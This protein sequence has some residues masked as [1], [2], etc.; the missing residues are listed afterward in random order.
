MTD[1]AGASQSLWLCTTRTCNFDC[2][3]CYQGSHASIPAGL[4]KHM[5]PEVMA[6]ALP[7]AV[8]WTTK[9]LHV[10]WYG[11]EPLLSFKMVRD[12]VPRW[13]EGFAQAGKSLSWSVTTNGS[14]LT[15]EV[16]AWLDEHDF[17]VL[18]SLDGPPRTHDQTRVFYDLDSATGR[19][20]GTWSSIPVNEILAWRPK[21]EL[22]WQLDPA[23]DFA[24]EDLDELLEMGF[25]NI[26]FN[27]NWLVEWPPEARVRLEVFMRAVA[28]RCITGRMSSN[29]MQK[30]EQA[31]TVDQKMAVPCGT[32]LAMLGL[33]PEGWLYPSQEMVYTAVRPDRAPGTDLY[34]RV[35]DV[36]RSPVIDQV[37][38]R[39]VSAIRTEQMK[40][41]APFNCEN[42]IAKSASIGG[43]H[44]RYVGM[45]GHDP[46]NRY[47][48]LPGYCQSMVSAM[49]G[50]VQGAC[51]ERWVRPVKWMAE[52]RASGR[53]ATGLLE[54]AKRDPGQETLALVRR[55]A[56][57][58][59]NL[60]LLPENT[61]RSSDRR[62]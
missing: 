49:T 1:M 28:R 42:C 4:A 61:E 56:R 57:Q 59:E 11:G 29:W 25:R 44:C 46:A 31:L 13:N 16:R 7:W 15:P 26:C 33:S 14:L 60:E 3:Y 20:R 43:C 48:V 55:I 5:P 54:V 34:Y 39:R 53:T 62:G 18:L 40:P 58:L 22:A 8:S 38:L 27:L 21:V 36:L 32:G 30:L 12:Q 35:G 19:R 9:A 24:V 10:C 41:P 17:G 52:Q 50:M 37:A 2:A 6:A 45:D 23:I 47:D 51:I